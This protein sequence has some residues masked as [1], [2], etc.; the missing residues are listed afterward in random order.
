MNQRCAGAALI[1]AAALPPPLAAAP[2]PATHPAPHHRPAA[3]QTTAAGNLQVSSWFS[4]DD[5]ATRTARAWTGRNTLIVRPQDTAHSITV[6]EKRRDMRND[7]WRQD[8]EAHANSYEASNSGAA[9]SPYTSYPEWS[10]P[11]EEHAMSAVKS[12][13]GICGWPLT[14]PEPDQSQP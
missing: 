4:L 9:S 2:P 6:Y 5:D 3:P 1:L 7:N 14:C 11:Q 12:A 13:L 8:I 10:S